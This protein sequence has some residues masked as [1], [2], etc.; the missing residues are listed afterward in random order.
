MSKKINF[1]GL[2]IKPS[3]EAFEVARIEDKFKINT[4]LLYFGRHEFDMKDHSQEESI[5]PITPSII[6]SASK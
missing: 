6:N 5:V 3:L 2:T 4:G 1:L